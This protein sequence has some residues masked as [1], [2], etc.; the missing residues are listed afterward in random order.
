MPFQIPPRSRL[1]SKSPFR[2]S[3]SRMP[4][5]STFYIS[6]DSLALGNET[7][8]TVD[9]GKAREEEPTIPSGWSLEVGRYLQDMTTAARAKDYHHSLG[10]VNQDGDTMYGNVENVRAALHDQKFWMAVVVMENATKAMNHAY[11]VG[12]EPYDPN[13]A[14]SVF[15]EES[16]NALVI[17]QAVY[18]KLLDFLNK[19]VLE[20]TKQKQSSL[21]QGINGS[22]VTA[23]QRQAQN[24]VAAG[25]TVFNMAPATPSTAE[26]ATE[27][28]TIYLIIVSFLS[29]LMF[30]KLSDT[31][32]GTIPM[33]TYYIYRIA[34]LP[35]VYFFLSLFYL[36]LSCMWHIPF[37]LH[38]GSAGYVL[39]WML[40][41]ISMMAFGLTIENINN[42]LGMPFTPVFFVFWVISNVTTGFYPTE[43]LSNFYKWGIVW[44]LRHDI[45]GARAIIYGTKNTLRLNFGVLIG[46][47]L[48]SLLLM[49]GTVWL[50]MRKKREIREERSRVVLE[51][52]WGAPG[53]EKGGRL[54]LPKLSPPN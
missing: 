5:Y 30:D 46:W 43:I 10:F 29:V 41:W 3:R 36:T 45:M 16:R 4:P 13:Q 39:Y 54:R 19:F 37:S 31:I 48:V 35:F 42:L 12:D 25:F 47:V 51:K 27:I 14:I 17:A 52:V 1:D 44:P 15:Y 26:A 34:V 53:K 21:L 23:L 24:P 33:R 8:D 50:Q 18:P 7:D 32:M 49:P 22:D 40:S 9:K 38:F 11:E 6:A 20:F 28:G 2:L